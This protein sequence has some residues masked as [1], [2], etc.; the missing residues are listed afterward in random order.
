MKSNQR[1]NILES[2]PIND[3]VNVPLLFFFNQE[4]SE[5]QQN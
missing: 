3:G 2:K 5:Q 4:I 1:I